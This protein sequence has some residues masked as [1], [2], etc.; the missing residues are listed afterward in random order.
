MN[1]NLLPA[2]STPSWPEFRKNKIAWIYIVLQRWLH[3]ARNPISNYFTQV[4]HAKSKFYTHLLWILIFRPL[5][6][7]QV[8]WNSKKVPKSL[9]FTLY[10][11]ILYCYIVLEIPKI[12]FT[13]VQHAESNF[14]TLL[15]RISV[16]RP[17]N[18]R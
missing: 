15:L 13:Q 4:Q 1:F 14:H 2:L 6:P 3:C 7:H 12:T 17:Q 5:C 18:L 8:G 10:C 9:E 16:V 11:Y